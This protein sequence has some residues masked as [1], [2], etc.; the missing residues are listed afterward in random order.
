LTND[1]EISRVLI[2]C[3]PGRRFEALRALAAQLPAEIIHAKSCGAAR[4]GLAIDPGPDVVLSA[5]TLEDGNWECV[6]RAMIE[7]SDEGNLIV[8]CATKPGRLQDEL[9]ARGVG[10]PLQEPY[11][12]EALNLLHDAWRRGR[13][14]RLGG[15][16]DKAERQST[17]S[18]G[19]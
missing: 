3:P 1:S 15:L 18:A 4:A 5:V 16:A 14:R 2:V 12:P 11:G 7:H 17:A 9:A 6:H 8:A 10:G 13:A 19:R